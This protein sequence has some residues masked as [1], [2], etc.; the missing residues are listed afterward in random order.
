MKRELSAFAPAACSAFRKYLG[1][2]FDILIGG[3]RSDA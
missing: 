1:G 3:S 2:V